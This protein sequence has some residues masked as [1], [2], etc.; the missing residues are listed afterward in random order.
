MF[1]RLLGLSSVMRQRIAA[2]RRPEFSVGIDGLTITRNHIPRQVSWADITK[3]AAFKRDIYL[4][5][6]VCLAIEMEDG[7]TEHVIEGDDAWLDVMEALHTNL[8]G[9]AKRENWFLDM[10][11][12]K[13]DVILIYD[14][15]GD[16]L[17]HEA[18]F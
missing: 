11:A 2:K 5:I 1:Q 8:P 7:A 12:G 18:K 16:A 17:R 10:A 15:G 9:I 6:V 14:R 4:G 13:Q 3:V